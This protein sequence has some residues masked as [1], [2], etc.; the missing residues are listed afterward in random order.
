MDGQVGC[1]NLDSQDSGEFH[2]ENEMIYLEA[3]LSMLHSSEP[4]RADSLD[5]VVSVS[6]LYTHLPVARVLHTMI[7]C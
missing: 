1:C 7:D 5:M 6:T 4:P 3:G 2:H